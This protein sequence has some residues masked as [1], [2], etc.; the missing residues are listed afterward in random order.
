M[1]ISIKIFIFLFLSI[2]LL[3]S[4]QAKEK[5]SPH[6]KLVDRLT[7]AEYVLEKAMGDPKT[8]IPRDILSKA[9]GIII[10][11]QYKFG[12]FV[13]GE[14]GYGVLVVRDIKTNEWKLPSFLTAGQA[15]FG[16][17]FGVKE[18]NY[19][20]LLMTDDT[21]RLACASRFDVGVDASA[22]AGPIGRESENFDLFKSPVLVYS[23]MQGLFAGA[24]IKGG[25]IAQDQKANHLFYNTTHDT[26]E[27]LLSNWFKLPVDGRPL[28]NRLKVYG[29]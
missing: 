25:W 15:S 21:L 29:P 18:K 27:I 17:Q 6:Q 9:K 14:G 3:G 20:F 23:T 13:G 24:S 10:L 16:F 19:I 22:V 5:V 1:R 28:I 4:I 8:A 7:T 11:N 2:G 12:L 26:P